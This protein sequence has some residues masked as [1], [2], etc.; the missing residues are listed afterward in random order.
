M[1]ILDYI[2]HVRS[3]GVVGIILVYGEDF[4]LIGTGNW[5]DC[6]MAD[7]DAVFTIRE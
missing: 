2:D 4:Q 3:Q 5:F 6:P 1:T 7:N